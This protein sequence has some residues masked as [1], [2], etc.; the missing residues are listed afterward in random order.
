MAVELRPATIADLDALSGLLAQLFAIEIDFAI[1]SDRQMRGLELLLNRPDA[2]I[3]VAEE[4]GKV[5][6]MGSLQT[7]I[8]TAEGG[9]A[10]LIEDLVVDAESRGR[11]IGG[12]LLDALC[13]QA[14]A[15]GMTRVQLLADRTNEPALTF[16]DSRGWQGTRMMMLR[17][18]LG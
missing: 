11:G 16:Y 15:K 8:S 12:R 4:E 9:V 18:Q 3:L 17:R 7:L 2:L 5:V 6:G 1:D 13:E 14:R 10:G